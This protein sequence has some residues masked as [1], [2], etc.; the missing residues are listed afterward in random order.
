MVKG[1]QER[2]LGVDQRF[3]TG[4]NWIKTGNMLP[5]VCCPESCVY[6]W[7]WW[8]EQS[9]PRA[10]EKSMSLFCS[11]RSGDQP[12]SFFWVPAW[13]FIELPGIIWAL[14]TIYIWADMGKLTVLKK[15]SELAGVMA[16]FRGRWNILCDFSKFKT[17]F[18]SLGWLLIHL[19]EKFFVSI[20]SRPAIITC[21]WKI[22]R[23]KHSPE[24]QKPH[25]LG[26][27][28]YTPYQNSQ[29]ESGS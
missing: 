12:H 9:P 13:L 7:K 2:Q 10:T 29:R 25:N 5:D 22:R 21:S 26:K 15:A 8:A 19:F 3:L 20:C 11:G 28:Q 16:N 14:D 23:I 1:Q 4:K 27:G 17:T 6:S 18:Y 24:P